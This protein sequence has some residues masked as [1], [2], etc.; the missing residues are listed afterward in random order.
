LSEIVTCQGL[1]PA[2]VKRS[3]GARDHFVIDSHPYGIPISK[4]LLLPN[5]CPLVSS[6]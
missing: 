3:D 5:P 1:N 2:D 4:R 6:P